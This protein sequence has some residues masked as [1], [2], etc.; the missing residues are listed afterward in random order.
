MRSF[1]CILFTFSLPL[2][3]DTIE[4]VAPAISSANGSALVTESRDAQQDAQKETLALDIEK[5]SQAFG[6]LLGKNI[7]EL[8]VKLDLAAV[9]QGLEDAKKGNPPPLNERQ[10]L[11]AINQLQDI[12]LKEEAEINLRES[13]EFLERNSATPEIVSL[14]KG[15][16]QYQVLS[17]GTGKQLTPNENLVLVKYIGKFVGGEVF[18]ETP[19]PE[20][21]DLS[22][23]ID[24]FRSGLLGMKEGE[25]RA[26]YIHPD[27]AY[28]TSGELP[29]NSLLNFEV[30]LVSIKTNETAEIKGETSVQVQALEPRETLR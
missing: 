19:S 7:E 13:E 3:A 5:I 6:H 23:T 22:T 8:G 11:E 18:T 28:G 25:K 14:E 30:E 2:M 10:C 17:E 29:P 9:I 27:L 20:M 15:K 1:F 26:L 21:L 16:L 12:A 4:Q 24:G